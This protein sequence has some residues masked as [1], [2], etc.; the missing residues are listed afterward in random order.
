MSA[1]DTTPA[2]TPLPPA[3]VENKLSHILGML[4]MLTS[5]G[6][7]F[8]GGVVPAGIAH[9]LLQIAIKTNAAHQALFGKPLDLANVRHVDLVE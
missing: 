2:P 4:D 6:L 5:V 7:L 3:T 9:T 1:P 8:P